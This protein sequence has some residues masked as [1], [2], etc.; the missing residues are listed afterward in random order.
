MTT[1]KNICIFCGSSNGRDPAYVDAARTFGKMLARENVGL[2]YGGGNVG[3][4]GELAKAVEAAGGNVLGIIPEFLVERERA[5]EGGHELVVVENMHQRKSLMVEKADAFVALPGGIGTLEE[6]VEQLTWFQLD[7]HQ[8]PVLL[9]NIKG[10]WN[11]LLD[12]L[13]HLKREN[14]LY[15]GLKYLVADRVED[16]LPKLHA[17]V[18]EVPT[19]AVAPGM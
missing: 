12:L 14:Y 1:L 17:A 9:A 3:M 16:I 18:E 15:G 2:V 6:M 7:R 4:M 10:F 8:K 19:K 13:A 5:Y 11:P